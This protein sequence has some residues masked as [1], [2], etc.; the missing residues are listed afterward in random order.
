MKEAARDQMAKLEVKL[1]EKEQEILG[2]KAKDVVGGIGG[3][4]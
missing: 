1:L 3:R 2:L 4:S